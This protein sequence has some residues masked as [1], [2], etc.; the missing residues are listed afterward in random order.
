MYLV[1]RLRR[2]LTC[3]YKRNLPGNLKKD[4][5]KTMHELRSIYLERFWLA[6]LVKL[7]FMMILTSYIHHSCYHRYK[8][9]GTEVKTHKYH[10][11]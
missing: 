1:D 9:N 10:K 5:Y 6:L 4:I 11:F 3:G 8:D 7:N 2:F